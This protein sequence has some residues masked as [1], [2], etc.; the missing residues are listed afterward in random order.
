MSL[1]SDKSIYY[2]NSTN[3]LGGTHS[4]F[5]FRLDIPPENKYEDV[6]LL[7]ANIPKSYYLIQSGQNTF[8][9][10][11][12][13]TEYTV[14]L[15]PGNYT[16]STMQTEIQTQLN[17]AGSYTYAIAFSSSTGKWT[18]SVTGNSG[19]QPKLIF[20][21]YVYEQLGFDR[22]S[23]N[24]FSG[25]QLT[26]SNVIKLQKEDT[27]YVKSDICQLYGNN[28]NSNTLQEIF[29]GGNVN[30]SNI[31]FNNVDVESYSKKFA[32]KQSNIFQFY[33]TNEDGLEIDLQGQNCVLVVML[34]RK[35]NMYQ[36]V[37]DFIKMTVMS[38]KP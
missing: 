30:Y 36:M 16:R 15:T 24:Q 37:K 9:L 19:V 35:E 12:N 29:I 23:E 38:E 33:I 4:N 11:E 26:S 21:T 31:Q 25:D 18:F 17:A 22:S 32:N 8:T 14:S 5:T 10:D 13:D 3:R 27:I 6:V 34:Y 1:I 28:A 2:V 7:S 20:T